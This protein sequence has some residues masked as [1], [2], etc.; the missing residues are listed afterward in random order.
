MTGQLSD[1]S[2]SKSVRVHNP[3]CILFGRQHKVDGMYGRG[4]RARL[5]ETPGEHAAPV[6]HIWVSPGYSVSTLPVTTGNSHPASMFYARLVTAF[7]A[8]LAMIG[9]RMLDLSNFKFHTQHST[10]MI[11]AA[12]LQQRC[13]PSH[14]VMTLPVPNVILNAVCQFASWK[15]DTGNFPAVN[16]WGRLRRG[17]VV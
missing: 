16:L 15:P 13:F 10:S 5:P 7:V 11:A 14:G 1:R 8:K 9:S 2:C 17:R 12:A 4:K 3:Y 6:R